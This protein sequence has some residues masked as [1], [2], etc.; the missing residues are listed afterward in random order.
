MSDAKTI[1]L[2]L[3]GRWYAAYGLACCPVHGDRHPSLSLSNA[4]DGRLLLKC[5]VG[6]DFRSILDALRGLGLV[7]GSGPTAQMDLAALARREAEERREADRRAERA[8]ALWWSSKP[9]QGTPAE[10]Y[11]RGRGVTCELP[12]TLRFHPSTPHP[13]GGRLPALVAAVE[14][15]ER[16]AVHRTFIRP[17]GGGKA[18]VDPPKAMLG[19]VRGGAV[20]LFSG[21]GP[22]VVAEGIETGL[23]LMCGLLDHYGSVWAA[24]S[25]ASFAA[26]NLPPEPGELIVATDG[27][28]VG[29]EAGDNLARRADRLGWSVSLLPAPEGHDFNDVLFA[30]V[31][32]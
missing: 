19:S 29:R 31:A 20:R 30:G 11:L 17:D 23:S 9:V 15:A 32:A 3:K 1:T 10:V 7:E 18:E 26:L 25:S 27:D 2:A 6:C 13:S 22:L 5:H 16:R 12:P 14:G 8:T 28:R 21:P 4:R 24:L